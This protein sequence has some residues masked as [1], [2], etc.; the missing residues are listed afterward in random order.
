MIKSI[1]SVKRAKYWIEGERSTDKQKLSQHLRSIDLLLSEITL[2]FLRMYWVSSVSVR[3]I[4]P[5]VWYP[6]YIH[7]PSPI[8]SFV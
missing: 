7:E 8:I 3:D 2:I 5:D 4:L 1:L 6:T